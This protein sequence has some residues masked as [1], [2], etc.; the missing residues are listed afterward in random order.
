MSI[1]RDRAGRTALHYA[2]L[3]NDV[4]QVEELL[5]S[6]NDPDVSDRQ[7]FTPLHFAAQQGALEAARALLD[8]GATVDPVN[9]YGN[10]SLWTATFNSRGRGDLIMLLRSRGADPWH[11]NKAG[12]TPIDLS[13]RIGNYNVAQ[14]F[15]DLGDE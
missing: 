3:E 5:R 10:T 11:V 7:G 8:A 13:R 1:E 9:V 4:D 6:G 14:F 2:A 12:R 15:A